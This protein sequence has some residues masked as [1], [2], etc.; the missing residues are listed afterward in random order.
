VNTPSG[1]S[2]SNNASVTYSSLAGVNPN[3]RSYSKG[4]V[5]DSVSV[6]V[7]APLITKSVTPSVVPLNGVANY[8]VTATVPASPIK[9]YDAAIIDTLPQY[10]N[11][12]ALTSFNCVGC[13]GSDAAPQLVGP[14]VTPDGDTVVGYSLGELDASAN[15]RVYT[16]VFAAK[17]DADGDLP[18]GTKLVR[19]Q[20]LVNNVAVG[21]NVES[22]LG[23]IAVNPLALPEYDTYVE[24]STTNKYNVPVIRLGKAADKPS[25]Q[26]DFP[27]DGDITYTFTVYNDGAVDAKDVLVRD[28]YRTNNNSY[29]NYVSSNLGTANIV[30]Q[31][32]GIVDV[33]IPTIAANSSETFTLTLRVGRIATNAD[34]TVTKPFV[35]TFSLLDF[36][37][38][39]NN[40]YID[41]IKETPS[42]SA[43]VIPEVPKVEVTK[44][45][46]AGTQNGKV[47]YGGN[48]VTYEIEVKNTGTGTAWDINLN[49]DFPNGFSIVNGTCTSVVIT[50]N[51]SPWW[52]FLNTNNF[53]LAPGTTATLQY[54]LSTPVNASVDQTVSNT[55]NTNWRG[56]GDN[57]SHYQNDE[58]ISYNQEDKV[59]VDLV[60]PTYSL[61]KGPKQ[62]D[63]ALIT[64]GGNG[65]Y[66]LTFVNTSAVDIK[67]AVLIDT[68]PDSLTYTSHLATKPAQ[69][70]ITQSGFVGK[71]IF[72]LENIPAGGTVFIR[73]MVT[74]DGTNPNP[75]LLE[76]NVTA[77]VAG[78]AVA[79]T[80]K[81]Y[82]LW[83]PDIEAPI[84]S[85]TANTPDVAPGGQTTFTVDMTVQTNI[86]D[87]YDVTF[88]DNLPDGLAYVSTGTPTC[89]GAC[90][91][92][93]PAFV[94]PTPNGNRTDIG[95]WFGDVAPGVTEK[96][97][98]LLIQFKLKDS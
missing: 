10:F 1:S 47:A 34:S 32:S 29:L 64:E 66:Q 97:G 41:Y 44:R 9:L 5:T 62:T 46:I 68:L 89:V 61:I 23:G 78:T 74:Q 51:T 58:Y 56:T 52:N 20:D 49:D 82:L 55:V 84:A 86:V 6:G 85:K 26:T 69:T 45:I 90:T 15:D 30:N 27:K 42:V 16:W 92:P 83:S 25:T 24:A 53:D 79:K 40:N 33:L 73:L 43:T 31:Y 12:D 75:D 81:G 3:E 91:L 93:T 77:T 19:G 63:G 17:L 71:P 95:W 8:T 87:L 65:E 96:L 11:Y 80:A 4:P 21:L 14:S 28:Y 39:Q 57:S 50:C 13:P 37:D 94:G 59:D 18:N 38:V 67:S 88:I 2:V 76:N 54:Q 60:Q 48:A 72:T 7:P 36:N 22:R 98:E 70:T 35:D